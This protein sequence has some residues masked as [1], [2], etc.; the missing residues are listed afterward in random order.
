MN[1]LEGYT[2]G[3]DLL[4]RNPKDHYPISSYWQEKHYTG[5]QNFYKHPFNDTFTFYSTKW[6][7][8]QGE[9]RDYYTDRP[10]Y[11][12][13]EGEVEVTEVCVSVEDKD[14][15]W[16]IILTTKTYKCGGMGSSCIKK[17]GVNEETLLASGN[18]YSTFE[19]SLFN[20][21]E[22]YKLPWN[23][24]YNNIYCVPLCL[25]QYIIK[26]AKTDK[27]FAGMIGEDLY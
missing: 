12:C 20:V 27:R 15:S 24:R 5:R 3:E 14:N 8:K 10:I 19:S 23:F 6:I 1:C 21:L 9:F 26:E 18:D 17:D 16:K 11:L 4:V 7:V 13:Q 25:W 2:I 22:E